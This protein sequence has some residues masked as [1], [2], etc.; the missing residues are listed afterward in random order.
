MKRQSMQTKVFFCNEGKEAKGLMTA[1]PKISTTSALKEN[2]TVGWLWQ[3][4]RPREN[5]DII[6]DT[7]GK[8]MCLQFYIQILLIVNA[9]IAIN[10]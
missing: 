3:Q 8:D 10:V 6:K 4:F 5:G 7:E 2:Y 9:A 1:M